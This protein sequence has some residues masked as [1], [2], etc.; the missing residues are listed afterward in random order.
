MLRVFISSSEPMLA[1]ISP[2]QLIPFSAYIM[3]EAFN[4]AAVIFAFLAS[5]IPP[6]ETVKLP[7]PMFILPPTIDAPDTV[8]EKVAFPPLSTVIFLAL[9]VKC[10]VVSSMAF[11]V[12]FNSEF[13]CDVTSPFFTISEISWAV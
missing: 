11:P 10:P 13:I 4:V 2:L 7:F 9:I 12:T 6:E 5:T 3:P 8:P 1:S